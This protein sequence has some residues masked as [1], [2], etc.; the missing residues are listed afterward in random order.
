LGVRTEGTSDMNTPPP[1]VVISRF[2]VTSDEQLSKMADGP[3]QFPTWNREELS[4]QIQEVDGSTRSE[5]EMQIDAFERSF[6]DALSAS[7]PNRDALGDTKEWL[8]FASRHNTEGD[9]IQRRVSD[10][11]RAR[12]AEI[13]AGKRF[14]EL[15]GNVRKEAIEL[16][17]DQLGAL[18][19]PRLQTRAVEHGDP[20]SAILNQP[21]ALQLRGGLG[22]FYEY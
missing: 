1:R 5:A 13:G 8:V 16:R 15:P 4:R 20:A 11:G 2:D 6:R 3:S 17:L 14:G 19:G 10:R 12:P 7:P 21:G 18:A 9:L 22:A